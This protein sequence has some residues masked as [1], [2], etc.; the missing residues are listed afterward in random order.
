MHLCILT[1]IASLHILRLQMHKD[2]VTRKSINGKNDYQITVLVPVELA[3]LA[4]KAAI[5]QNT[6][7]GQ[8]VRDG[9]ILRLAAKQEGTH[10]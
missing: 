10:E 3:K 6:T 5:D 9:L 1:S 2:T 7:L 8:I 4:K